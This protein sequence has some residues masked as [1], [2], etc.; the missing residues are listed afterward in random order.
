MRAT[1]ITNWSTAYTPPSTLISYDCG[2]EVGAH[3]GDGRAHGGAGLVCTARGVGG[4]VIGR[5]PTMFAGGIRD[6]SLAWM[7]LII[8]GAIWRAR[9]SRWS[10]QAA[11]RSRVVV[12]GS[13]S[14][15]LWP[16]SELDAEIAISFAQPPW[17][18]CVGG[19]S[20]GVAA[21]VV[22]SFIVATACSLMDGTGTRPNAPTGLVQRIGIVTGW[23]WFAALTFSQWTARRLSRLMKY[24]Y[25]GLPWVPRPRRSARYSGGA[26]EVLRAMAEAL[27]V[28]RQLIQCLPSV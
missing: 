18:R 7:E 23:F 9:F 8:A 14:D 15:L 22:L 10:E 2:C 25:S 26:F 4:V 28:L 16:A 3:Y 27:I 11:G 21:I 5:P 6:S 12:H 17:G 13:G 20:L 24:A 19:V 1:W